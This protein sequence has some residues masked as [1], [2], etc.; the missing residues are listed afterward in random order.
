MVLF[1]SLCGQVPRVLCGSWFLKTPPLPEE[2]SK[3]S[4][5]RS[6]GSP[7]CSLFYTG[8]LG[9]PVDKD[10]GSKWFLTS[11]HRGRLLSLVSPKD[12]IVSHRQHVQNEH[13]CSFVSVPETESRRNNSYI[14]FP[15]SKKNGGLSVLG[16]IKERLDWKNYISSLTKGRS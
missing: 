2:W 10:W 11:W 12:F 4:R 5:N 7:K 3:C 16:S 14:H 15:G 1:G 6:T 8:D 13:S 9:C